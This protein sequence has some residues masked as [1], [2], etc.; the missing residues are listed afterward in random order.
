MTAR[1]ARS[2]RTARP[3]PQSR[4][5]PAR[6]RPSRLHLNIVAV[7]VAAVLG[8]V[9]WRVSTSESSAPAGAAFTGADFH[10]IV[11]D[12]T[13]S[14]VLYVGG[15]QAVSRSTDAGTTWER[16]T[17]LDDADAMGWGFTDD[18]MYVSGHPGLTVARAGLASFARD[19]A[20]L[21][22]TDL[23]AL[24][25]GGGTVYAAGP[26]AGV[27]ASTDG[28]AT[29]ETRTRDA[30][31]PFFGRIIVDDDA[32]TLTA[33]DT[34]QGP[35]RSTDGGHTWTPLGGPPS[36]W[37]TRTPD[38][39]IIA[40]GGPQGAVMLANGS[41]TWEPLNS[42]DGAHL[43]EADP[44]VP[45]RLFAGRHSGTTVEVWVSTDAG[46]TWDRA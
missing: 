9:L 46:R 2:S 23:H 14:D 20:G 33:A 30:G 1:P 40:S 19:N 18:A 17:S 35:M 41:D 34:Q 3:R 16:V 22:D 7:A 39:T 8:V 31:Q 5:P 25:A 29:W 15:H 43:V 28:G 6:R 11:A 45:G 42:P 21:P 44:H 4:R 12:P 10:S 32:T 27:I 36:G 38:G 37:L 13:E 26:G 24:G